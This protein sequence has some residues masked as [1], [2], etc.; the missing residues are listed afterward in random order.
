LSGS[1]T[2]LHYQQVLE[3]VAFDDPGQDNP[4]EFGSDPTR[5]VSWT[6]NDGTSSFTATS[7]INVTAVNDPPTLA[8]LATSANFL[9]NGAATTL[10]NAVTVSDPDNLNI[11]SATIAVTA[12]SFAGDGDVLAVD[13]TGTSITASSD[14]AT[15]KLFLSGSDTPAHYQQVLDSLTFSSTS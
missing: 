4:T 13:T 12:G 8:N 14:P 15:E 2:L 7:T 10:S 9:E 3:S 5:T 6:V 1:D 11:A